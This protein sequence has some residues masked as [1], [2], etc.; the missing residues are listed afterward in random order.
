[1]EKIFEFLKDPIMVHYASSGISLLAAIIVIIAAISI[2]RNRKHIEKTTKLLGEAGIH[3]EATF[4][5]MLKTMGAISELRKQ[6]S[7]AP[8]QDLD[9]TIETVDKSI[10]LGKAIGAGMNPE[11]TIDLT[12]EIVLLEDEVKEKK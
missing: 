2:R 6:R 11:K 12:D 10:E 1:M 8:K 5:S 7:P 3:L 4:D 9:K